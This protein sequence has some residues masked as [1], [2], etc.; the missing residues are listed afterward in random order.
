MVCDMIISKYIFWPKAQLPHSQKTR[1]VTHPNMSVNGTN[2]EEGKIK[3]TSLP[4][5]HWNG[6]IQSFMIS[7]QLT[8][9]LEFSGKWQQRVK[10]RCT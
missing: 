4:W 5:P 6:N 10:L 7:S 2:R 3:E 1:L 9:A 8:G